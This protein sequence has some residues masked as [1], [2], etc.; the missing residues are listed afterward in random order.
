M[1]CSMVRSALKR[2]LGEGGVQRMLWL[3]QFGRGLL[4]PCKS[5]GD[6]IG[7]LY[8]QEAHVL[9]FCFFQV[10]LLLSDVFPRHWNAYQYLII[11]DQ[12]CLTINL[13]T[14]CMSIIS[15]QSS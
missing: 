14:Y 1:A 13:D 9:L 5:D 10:R 8:P 15:H 2:M 4:V 11:A 7:V 12:Q 6:A 3:G